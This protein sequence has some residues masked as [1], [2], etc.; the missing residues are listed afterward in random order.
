MRAGWPKSF[1]TLLVGC[2]A[3]LFPCFETPPLLGCLA[4]EFRDAPCGLSGSV[5]PVLRDAPCWAVWHV[6]K[7]FYKNQP[8]AGK[9]IYASENFSENQPDAGKIIYASENFCENQPDAGKIIYASELSL[10]SWHKEISAE[11]RSRMVER[12]RELK[13]AASDGLRSTKQVLSTKANVSK[14]R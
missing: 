4:R 10:K 11:S 13:K 14:C 8:D 5:G 1:E 3:L 9:I 7:D 12:L 2:L 6:R